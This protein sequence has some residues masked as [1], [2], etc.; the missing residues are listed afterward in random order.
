MVYQKVEAGHERIFA[1][2]DLKQGMN[3]VSIAIADGTLAA[4]R[5]GALSVGRAHPVSRKSIS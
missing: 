3:Q 1:L 4:P 5:S 2:E